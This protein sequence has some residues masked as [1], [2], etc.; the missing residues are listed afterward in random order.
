MILK[1][2]NQMAEAKWPD[3]N[4]S[5]RANVSIRVVPDRHLIGAWSC[6]KTG[7]HPGSSPAQAFSGSRS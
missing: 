7:L 6:P 4:G 1:F 5:A 2:A 3:P